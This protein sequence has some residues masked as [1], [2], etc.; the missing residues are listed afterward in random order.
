MSAAGAGRILAKVQQMAAM[1]GRS[2]RRTGA[3]GLAGALLFIG[4]TLADDAGVRERIEARLN[5]AHVTERGQID[6]E[7]K[8]GVAVL[9]GFTTTVDARHQA[10][11]AARKE[12]KTVDNRLRVVPVTMDDAGLRQ[13]VTDAVLGYVYYGVFDS[14]AIGVDHGVVTL[15]GSVRHPWRKEDIER[16]VARLE[17]VREIR[18][19]LRVQTVSGFDERLRRQLYRRI[20][21]NGMFQRYATFSDPPI[22]I[23][24]EKGNITLTGVVNSRVE[25]AVLE[26]IARGVL[27][28]RVDNQVQVESDIGKEPASKAVE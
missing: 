26:T 7:V 4:P 23:V 25:K 12:T 10:E 22:H 19:E 24:V 2:V 14:V 1:D 15:Q 13:S 6:V 17:G 27:A 3:L 11:K 16:R 18:N 8:D 5:K 9:S 28:F 21:G 20:Y